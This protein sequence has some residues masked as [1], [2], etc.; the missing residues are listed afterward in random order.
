MNKSKPRKIGP[1]S[2]PKSGRRHGGQPRQGSQKSGRGGAAGRDQVWLY[3]RHAVLAALANPNRD[4]RRLLVDAK[5]SEEVVTHLTAA[6]RTGGRDLPFEAVER[7]QL[8]SLLDEGALHQGVAL[9]ARMLNPLAIE[10]ILDLAP[11]AGSRRLLVA[12]DQVTDPRNVGAIFRS[13]AAFGAAGLLAPER[14]G[15]PESGALARAASGGIERV[16]R[17][18]VT[19][20]ARALNQLKAAGWW[21]VGLAE[22]SETLLADWRADARVV[23]VLGAEGDGLRHLTRKTCDQLLRLPTNPA[24]ASLNVSNAAAV[25]LY[26]LARPDD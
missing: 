10:D 23:L 25:A 15:A 21:V 14:H 8:D 6:Q 2:G 19:N 22:E 24:L 18:E 11:E 12:L 20:L 4:C 9:L 3:G 26:Q 17:I 16:P 7:R 13:A 5:L 1:E